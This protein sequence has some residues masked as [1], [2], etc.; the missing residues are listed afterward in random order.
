VT[1]QLPSK[2]ATPQQIEDVIMDL[3]KYAKWF[4]QASIKMK[5]KI[6]IG[7][8]PQISNEA[9]KLLDQVTSA[10][11]ITTKKIDGLINS[12]LDIKDDSPRLTLTLAARPTQDTKVQLIEWC[13]T[14]LSDQ[15]LVDFKMDRRLLG[16]MTVQYGSHIYDWSFQKLIN[17]NADKLPGMLR[18]V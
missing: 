5:G 4:S 18:N 2:I 3:E 15:V 7:D 8:P 10:D 17:Q 14:N 6:E 1:L 16:G 12:L 11:D 9:V 13:R